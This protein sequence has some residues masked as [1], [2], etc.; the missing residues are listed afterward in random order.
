MPNCDVNSSVITTTPSL[1]NLQTT[2]YKQKQNLCL[3]NLYSINLSA[4]GTATASHGE[5]VSL[6][7]HS[8]H[9]PSM[10]D[11]SSAASVSAPILSI[12]TSPDDADTIL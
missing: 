5:Q 6:N 3:N 12:L 4:D 7:L 10:L 8:T 11:S 1:T 2:R 9:K